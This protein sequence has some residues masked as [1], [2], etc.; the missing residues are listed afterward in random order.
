M[1]DPSGLVFVL[2]VLGVLWRIFSSRG[3]SGGTAAGQVRPMEGRLHHSPAGP[4]S[5]ERYDVQIRGLTRVRH[6]SSPM[7]TTSIVDMTSGAPQPV[8][9]MLNE[10]QADDSVIFQHRM[11]LG[12]WNSSILGTSDWTSI[13]PIFPVTLRAPR[14]GRRTLKVLVQIHDALNED[15]V[16]YFEALDLS[17]ELS[18]IGWEEFSE[19]RSADEAAIVRLAMGV[20]A[21]S[22][23]LHEAELGVIKAWASEQVA[24]L[25]GDPRDRKK[26]DLNVAIREGARDA[27]AGDISLSAEVDLLHRNGTPGGRLEAIELCLAVASADGT[28]DRQEL[29]SINQIADRLEVDRDWFSGARD[30]ALRGTQLEVGV[31]DDL[32]ALLGIDRR[33]PREDIRR[34]L[35][36]QYDRWSSRAVSLED[37]ARRAEAEQMLDLIA[38]ARE[39][40]K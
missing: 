32:A 28:A 7:A 37:P 19:R 21:A 4:E 34:E 6:G 30:K 18:E 24:I 33:A 25:E 12:F 13:A 5:P 38:R 39:E 2:I 3:A 8:I 27:S 23:G 20:A 9:A 36:A 14:S 17:V 22:G 15:E 31:A 40:L 16:F 11:A 35:T 1:D 10:Q 29:E 26:R